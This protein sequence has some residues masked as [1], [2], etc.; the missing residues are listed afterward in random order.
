MKSLAETG[1]AAAAVNDI[2]EKVAREEREKRVVFD[3]FAAFADG[4]VKQLKGG[5]RK[6]AL[7]LKD[8]IV[9]ALLGRTGHSPPPTVSFSDSSR[10]H[11]SASTY[12]GALKTRTNTGAAGPIKAP[13]TAT[14]STPVSGPSVDKK[15]ARKIKAEKD[16]I[17][18]TILIAANGD[19]LLQEPSPFL[20][21]L[22]ITRAVPELTLEEIPYLQ[23]NNTGWSLRCNTPATREKVM[24]KQNAERLRTALGATEVRR[25]EKWYLYAV[26]QVPHDFYR[27]GGAPAP[28]PDE[29]VREEIKSQTGKHPVV[30]RLSRNGVHPTTQR[31]TWIV[32]FTASVKS[33]QLFNSSSFSVLL[34]KPRSIQLH[35]TGCQGYCNPFT[36]KK[37]ARCSRCGKQNA[38]HAEGA[39]HERC[40]RD[41]QC[42]NCHGPF[43]AG[44]KNCPAAPKVHAKKIITQTAKSLV[45]IRAEG[46]KAYNM[47]KS[48][49][50]AE[51]T[52]PTPVLP[53]SSTIRAPGAQV[54]EHENARPAKRPREPTTPISVQT[55]TST[56]ITRSRPAPNLN[57]VA[58]A[59][60]VFGETLTSPIAPTDNMD[61][62]PV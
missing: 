60:R 20:L 43:V 3:A 13:T 48:V 32:G 35:S 46:R 14:S 4:L 18:R 37:T 22:K 45:A 8:I 9:D 51:V 49:K 53:T 28:I 29:L 21:R 52:R 12:A 26:P 36:C 23:R 31:G 56:R 25:L 24:E 15:E 17:E 47:L 50:E 61:T 10:A 2:F 39:S 38:E 55:A 62:T 44:H 30:C 16:R 34:D 40:T 19:A 11:S 1:S 6:R 7:D 42:A 27:V 59:N 33:F 54:T 58:L 5:E 41:A 57:E